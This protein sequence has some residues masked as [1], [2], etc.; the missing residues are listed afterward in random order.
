MTTTTNLFSSF[1]NVI[2]LDLPNLDLLQVNSVLTNHPEWKQYNP[3]KVNKR[4][5]LSVTSLD[6]GYSGIPDLDSVYEYNNLYGTSYSEKDFNV[7]TP[8][9]HELTGLEEI[10]NTFPNL[11]RCHFLKLNAG[12]HFPPHRDNGLII[13]S[14]TLRVI[15]PLTNTGKHDWKW[16]QEDR[17]LTLETGKGYCINTTKEHS[18]FSFI[19]NCT[20]LV[21]NLI[22]TPQTLNSIA[23]NIRIR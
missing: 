1:G 23:K 6:G 11:G 10:L 12:G 9:V 14:M 20:M 19:D 13:P 3:R 22:A 5:G 2:E 17:L 16:I 18:I 21:L 4:L 15:I 7:R 8:I